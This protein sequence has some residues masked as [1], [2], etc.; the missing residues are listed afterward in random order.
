ML[1]AAKIIEENMTEPPSLLELSRKIGIND[2]K[3]KKNFKL[4]FGN[5]VYGY[6]NDKRMIR[7]SELLLNGELSVT[8][9]FHQVGYKH[10]G[11]V[12]KIFKERFL[13]SPKHYKGECLT[14]AAEP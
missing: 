7:A 3:L 4:V 5:T 11:Y 14:M 2:S 6:L 10:V 12:S 1:Q 8:E 9:V 13:C